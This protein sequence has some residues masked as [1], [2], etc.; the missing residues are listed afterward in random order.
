MIQID[1]PKRRVYIKFATSDM[2]H[3]VLQITAG[4]L[5]YIHDNGV[6]SKVLIELAGMGIRKIWIATLPP[7]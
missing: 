3:Q 4:Q 5:E 2:V 6:I 1:G 7:K